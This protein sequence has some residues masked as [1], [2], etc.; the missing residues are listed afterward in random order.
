MDGWLA[1]LFG[2]CNGMISET[3]VSRLVQNHYLEQKFCFAFPIDI[4]SIIE[5]EKMMITL[6]PKMQLPIDLL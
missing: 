6:M 2:K 5:K 1:V 3:Q 4:L